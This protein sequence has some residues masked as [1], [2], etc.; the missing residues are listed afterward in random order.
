MSVTFSDQLHAIVEK[1]WIERKRRIASSIGELCCS[2][3]L[4]LVINLIF[5]ISLPVT[6]PAGNMLPYTIREPSFYQLLKAMDEVKYTL[7]VTHD[8]QGSDAYISACEASVESFTSKAG[9]LFNGTDYSAFNLSGGYYD[10]STVP[11]FEVSG[12]NGVLHPHHF[13]NEAA[14]DEYIRSPLYKANDSFPP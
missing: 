13:E 11:N 3:A 2:I 14:L 9:K 5:L 8:C 1:Q 7:V 10:F 4:L 6:L 12:F